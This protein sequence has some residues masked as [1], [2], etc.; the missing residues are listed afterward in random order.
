MKNRSVMRLRELV[1]QVSLERLEELRLAAAS[2]GK[3]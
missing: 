2:E 3:A 1:E